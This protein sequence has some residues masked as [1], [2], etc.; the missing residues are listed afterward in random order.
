M[1]NYQK[2]AALSERESPRWKQVKVAAA[3][4]VLLATVTTAGGCGT[5]ASSAASQSE[6]EQG[7]ISI[8]EAVSF[9]PLDISSMNP[10]QIATYLNYFEPGAGSKGALFQASQYLITKARNPD[11]VV[12]YDSFA[13]SDSPVLNVFDEIAL[14]A[15]IAGTNSDDDIIVVCDART[16]V[17]SANPN[18]L[19]ADLP[20]SEIYASDTGQDGT[21]LLV[22]AQY[23]GSGLGPEVTLIK[24]GEEG[25]DDG[26][27]DHYAPVGAEQGDDGVLRLVPLRNS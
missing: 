11:A 7:V 18:P 27:F 26:S 3:V 23:N 10:G 21:G 22:V 4:I 14:E 15:G 24:L 17:P 9:D 5:D 16:T 25:G 6:A 2:V 20:L 19:C 1:Q 12:A 13:T 8:G